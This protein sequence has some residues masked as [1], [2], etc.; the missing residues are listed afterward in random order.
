MSESKKTIP[1][2]FKKDIDIEDLPVV[3]IV[4]PSD[5][6][7]DTLS[8]EKQS[9]E[10]NHS[11]EKNKPVEADNRVDIKEIKIT[12]TTDDDDE[13]GEVLEI[14]EAKFVPK[15][16]EDLQHEMF[17]RIM[18]N[19]M[20]RDVHVALQSNILVQVEIRK[21]AEQIYE[22]KKRGDHIVTRKAK[23]VTHILN[24]LNT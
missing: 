7:T 24:I 5:V 9:S 20:L 6:E 17:V 13:F 14:T 8:E 23:M 1:K 21:K 11:I 3:E 19:D 4:D 16:E 2:K 10:S 15:H 22:L 12:P 18:E